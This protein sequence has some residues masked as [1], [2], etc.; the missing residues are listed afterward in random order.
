MMTIDSGGNHDGSPAGLLSAP[1]TD[2]YSLPFGRTYPYMWIKTIQAS[3]SIEYPEDERW[4]TVG[5]KLYDTYIVINP[6]SGMD[7]IDPGSGG[8][9]DPIDPDINI[10]G[11]TGPIDP[12]VNTSNE[13]GSGNT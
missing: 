13:S 3:E 12:G 8:G 4:N 10:G 9:M 7:P 5:W 6:G 11:G 2:P 1:S